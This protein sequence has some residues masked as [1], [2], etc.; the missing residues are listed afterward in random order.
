[1]FELLFCSMLTIL[2]D[3]LFRRY[4]QGKRI[5]REIT[6]Y[7][8]WFELRWGIIGCTT[9]T[10]TLITI[11][12]YYHPSTSNATSFFR[13][14]PILP[15]G[16]GRVEEI[17][18]ERN[19]TTPVKAGDKIFTLDSSKQKAALEV[20]T[21]RIKEVDASIVVAESELVTADGQIQQAQA[22]YQQALD[23]LETKTELRK[24]NANVVAPRDLEKLQNTVNARKGTLAAAQA[25]K[26]SIQ[27]Q[28]NVLLPAQKASA[29]AA[30]KQAQ[31]DLEK[32]TVYAGTDG[33]VTQFTLHL[34]D[35]VNPLMRP[36]GV[37]VPKDA[38]GQGI[39]AGFNQIEAQVLTVGMIAEITCV[40]KP[41]SIIPM[42]V[43]EVQESIAAGQVRSSDQLF[44]PAKVQAPGTVTVFLEPLYEG[45][46]DGIPL[47][48]S[49]L[50]FAYTNNHEKL[51]SGDIGTGEWLFLHVVDTVSVVHAAGLRI[52]ALLLPIQTLVLTGH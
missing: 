35:I 30:L 45:G 17:F 18:V 14:V 32:M 39:V 48:S 34:G 1:M 15:E 41:Y 37:L 25:S 47:G 33:M 19:L 36:A 16:T 22:S 26:E 51:A 3:Y 24:R 2:P 38:G 50:A 28:I 8:V 20:A 29:E 4:V 42:V 40:S 49:C 12:F 31:V 27:T 6:L 13:T 44:D 11:I 10:L 23:E 7:S 5:G 21:R 9:L 43:T 52:R 46:L